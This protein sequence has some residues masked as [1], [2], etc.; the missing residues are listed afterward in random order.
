MFPNRLISYFRNTNIRIIWNLVLCFPSKFSSPG[1]SN[2]SWRNLNTRENT[3][4]RNSQRISV[5]RRSCWYKEHISSQINGN[6]R[7]LT[8]LFNKIYDFDDFVEKAV[9]INW[10]FFVAVISRRIMQWI[11]LQWRA[12][13]STL[14]ATRLWAPVP[15][16]VCVY[17]S[18][19]L[20]VQ[21]MFSTRNVRGLQLLLL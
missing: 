7:E 14:A 3:F 2:N 12:T 21:T 5:S 10:Y 13:S 11:A 4:S 1:K 16:T 6:K 18:T 15:A 19:A 17:T 20:P 8:V 9:K